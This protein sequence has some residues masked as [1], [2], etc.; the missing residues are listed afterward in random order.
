[1]RIAIP[2]GRLQDNVL[3]TFAA[4]GYDVPTIAELKTRKLVF[5]RGGVEWIFVKDCDVPVYV[6]HGAADVGVAGLD[7]ILEHECTAFQAV[8]LPYGRCRMMLIGAP[9]APRLSRDITAKIATKYPRIARQ[10]LD[11]RALRAELVPLG[12]SVELA[13]VLSLTSHVIDLVETGETVRVHK[14]PEQDFV[15]EITP[16][17]LVS[18]NIYRTANKQVRALITRI[19]DAKNELVSSNVA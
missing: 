3:A 6:E 15:A 12:G 4:A 17:L 19:E 11:T 1:M 14:L 7:Q 18:K 2:K 16:R 10:Y 13:A 5:A 9:D 8:E